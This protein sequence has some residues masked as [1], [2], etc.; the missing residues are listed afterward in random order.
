MIDNEDRTDEACIGDLT[1]LEARA[2]GLA[3]IIVR[4]L[5]RDTKELVEIGFPVFSYGTCPAG[6][7]R[8]DQRQPDDLISAQWNG[9]T[10][11]KRSL[12]FADNDGVVFVEA[13]KIQQI[14]DTAESI[15][16]IERRQ[17][18]RIK[19][20]RKLTEQLAFGEYLA[21]RSANPS[22]TFRKHLRER[23]GAIEE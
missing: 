8:L 20:G 5:H 18:R 15:W 9:F 23:D 22:F 13:N 11:D 19:A 12:V 1:V 14:M 4:G 16:K 2:H 21:K 7:Q 17:A 3:G 6:P 10:V